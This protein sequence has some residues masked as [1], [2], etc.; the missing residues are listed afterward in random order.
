M[1][2]PDLFDP[3]SKVG[4]EF[5]VA[6]T[7]L[8]E[9]VGCIVDLFPWLRWLDPQGLR[10]KMDQDMGTAMGIASELVRETI[11]ENKIGGKMIGGIFWTGII[12]GPYGNN[13][14]HHRVGT[15]RTT[16]PG[17]HGQGPS[18]AVPGRQVD[19]K[20][21][22]TDID[23]L[24]Y[25]QAVVKET[26]R[27]HP[28]I[29]C[30]VPRRVARD[31]I[32]MGYDIPENTQVF[33][34]AGAIGRDPDFWE[35][36]MA[37]KPERFIGSKLDYKGQH[38]EFIPFGAGRRMCAGVPLAHRVLHLA[39]GTPF[40]EFNWEFDCRIDPKMIDM[41]DRMGVT[42]KKYVPLLVVPKRRAT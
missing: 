4:S 25:L 23:Q 40:H 7:G 17:I 9:W 30:L 1:L 14:Q 28:P 8:M 41:R 33:V 6:M 5:F 16:E 38:Y 36:P 26:F 35:D 24:P 13:K 10:R 27:L 42:T 12:L 21:P 37:F 11:E 32:F 22:G 19:P 34:N 3:D 39:L 15:D 20:G 31:T 18:R 29:P 2:S